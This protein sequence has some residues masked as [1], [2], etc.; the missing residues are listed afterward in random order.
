MATR[1]KASAEVSMTVVC[2]A[3]GDRHF[4]YDALVRCYEDNWPWR[5]ARGMGNDPTDREGGGGAGRV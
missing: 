5:R 4:S 2:T 3:C 1:K